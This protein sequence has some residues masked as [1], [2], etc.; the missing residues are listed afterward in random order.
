MY[1][2]MELKGKQ[3]VLGI[4][5]SVPCVEEGIKVTMSVTESALGICET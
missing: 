5:L 3:N 1:V 2:W 4:T